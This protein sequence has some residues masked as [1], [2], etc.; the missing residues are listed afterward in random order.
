MAFG[1]AS[2]LA[3]VLAGYD[4]KWKSRQQYLDSASSLAVDS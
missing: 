3:G 4:D 2:V 1:G